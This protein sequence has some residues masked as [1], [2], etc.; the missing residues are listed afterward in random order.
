MFKILN[1]RR[2]DLIVCRIRKALKPNEMAKRSV[3]KS[4][5]T[6]EVNNHGKLAKFLVQS[7]LHLLFFSIFTTKP[8]C[9]AK[10]TGYTVKRVSSIS[11]CIVVERRGKSQQIRFSHSFR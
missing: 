11:M 6:S 5:F 9:V 1:K 8:V 4:I 3:N 10:T 2:I 7:C